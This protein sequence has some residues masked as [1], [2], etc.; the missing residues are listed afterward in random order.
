MYMP[1]LQESTSP[2]TVIPAP[3]RTLFLSTL[4]SPM[5]WF[6][7]NVLLSETWLHFEY[8]TL[9]GNKRHHVVNKCVGRQWNVMLGQEFQGDW[10]IVVLQY[11]RT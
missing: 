11:W 1:C 3:K 10:C 6:G 5:P 7:Q 8:F 9:F 2:N 4:F